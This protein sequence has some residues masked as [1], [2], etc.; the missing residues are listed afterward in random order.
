MTRLKNLP[1]EYA[2]QQQKNKSQNNY[3]FYVYKKI[4]TQNKLPGLGT[5]PG[6][7]SSGYYHNVLS[8]NTSDIESYLYGI[9]QENMIKKFD[10]RP[11]LNKLNEQKFFNAPQ[12]VIIPQ[13]LVI[14]KYQ[15]P[16]APFSSV[17]Y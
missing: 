1:G 17:D 15:R 5:N 4:P 9:G 13:P 2:L 8:N 16:D 3:K 14:E 10:V 7:M 6:N 11:E 12:N